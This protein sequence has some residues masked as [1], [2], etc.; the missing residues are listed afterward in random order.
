MEEKENGSMVG[1]EAVVRR[2]AEAVE[3]I[4]VISEYRNAYRKPLC[5][6]ARRIRLLAP[7]F[8]ELGDGRDPITE[9]VART[10]APLDDAFAAAKDLLRLGSEGSKIFLVLE[11]EKMIKRFHD[12]I[13]QIDQA[14]D[15]IS[16]DKLEISEE[17]REQIELVH[18]Q[19]KRAKER[20][21]MP[22]AELYSNLLSL[23]NKSNDAILDPYTLERLA[24][25]LQLVTICDLTQESLAL[26]EMVFASGGDP[27][28]NIEKMSMLLKKIKDF[29]QTQN[30]EMGTRSDSKPFLLDG[31]PKVPIVPDDFRCPIS[32][33]LMKDPVIVATG[34]TYERTCIE[35]WLASGHD[36]CPKTQ[37]RLSN[38]SL[39]PNYVLRSLIEQ[40]CEANGMDPP[41]CP[42][43]STNPS[44]ACSSRE[45]ANIDALL[46]KLSSP[47][48]DDQLAAAGELRLLAKRNVDNR[49][50]IAKA[51][52]IPLLINLLSS[53]NLCTQ[54]HAV[55]ALLNLSIHDD[56]KAIII[57][58]GAIP[59]I[60]H[61]LRDGSMEARENAA[62]TLF[63]L[64][65]VDEYKVTVGASGAIPAL[66][67]LLSEGTHRGKKDA[68]TALFNLCIYQVN[69]GKAV[70]AGVV[71]LVMGL[72]TEP[73][74]S[75]LD[76][77][78]A[79][80]ALLSSHPEGKS[81]IAAAQAVPLLAEMTANGS[82]RNRENAA[83]TLLNLSDGE[84]QL[85]TMA[86][87]QE[88][89]I[90]GPLQELAI[91]GTERGKRKAVQLLERMNG[92][93][94]QQHEAYAQAEAST[95]TQGHIHAQSEPR[96][97][98]ASADSVDT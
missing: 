27:G 4:A 82:P 48:L 89:G 28:E 16:F 50:C 80:L 25:Q 73:A 18:A 30:P 37:Q 68:A 67:S 87:A 36:T 91:S 52:A 34:Q 47:N 10:L 40:W 72:L 45:L 66:V 81:A 59:G 7:M 33:E 35:K 21:D 93:L 9:P 15:G 97:N 44:S 92:F 12:V 54:E 85:G 76:E 49:I 58:S 65:V 1:G 74:E 90:M 98:V 29:V 2:L 84:Q 32:L 5:S 22:D 79:I 19:F 69:K 31:K 56:N 63:S 13:S 39:T 75:M 38:A 51:G 17:V 3:E 20:D 41:K 14:L 70:R 6:L 96:M 62:A 57:S 55:T 43:R 83:A 23:Y 95:Q 94:V 77:S 11:R 46:C 88:C 24:E 42:S 64:S 78:M 61:V 53:K 60:V 26:H 71:P 86:A 8:D